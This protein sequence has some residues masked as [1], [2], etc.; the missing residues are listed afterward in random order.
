[1]ILRCVG[2]NLLT[3]EVCVVGLELKL[4]DARWGLGE[5]IRGWG[6]RGALFFPGKLFSTESY[7]DPR[8]KTHLVPVPLTETK[9]GLLSLITSPGWTWGT[10]TPYQP[11]LKV[12]SPPV[13][14]PYQP[15]LK[16]I[17]PPGWIH[18][19]FLNGR[20]F[21]SDKSYEIVWTVSVTIVA[22]MAKECS[23]LDTH[24]LIVVAIGVIK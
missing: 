23:C 6:L 1:L 16:V 17:S 9:G 10:Y 11:G 4:L 7:Y 19:F 15:G 13:Y 2:C 24:L 8:L 18:M 14:T 20:G 22:N 21:G 12:L 3:C 5:G